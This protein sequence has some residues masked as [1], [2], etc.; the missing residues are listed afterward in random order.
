MR[1]IHFLLLGALILSGCGKLSNNIN[2]PLP[3]YDSQLVAECY[4]EPGVVPRLTVTESQTYLSSTLPVVP[5]DVMVSLS[6]PNGALVPLYYKPGQDPITKKYYTH[7]GNTPL[8]AQAGDTFGLD[9]QDTKGRHLT[10]TATMPTVVPIDSVAYKFNALTGADHKAYFLTYFQD[11]PTADDDYRLQLHQGR[12]I[13]GSA[14]VDLTIQ[15]RLINGQRVTLGT[16]YRFKPSDTITA[17][18]Y[19]IDPAYYRFRESVNDA[20]N[21]NGNP[22]GQPSAIYSTVAGGLGVFTVLSYTR[23]TMVL[24]AK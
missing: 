18:L 2:V 5:T 11:P 19:H 3:A 22:F 13:Y 12:R 15:D 7:I 17:T 6:L 10:G 9:V 8:V 1:S 4:L 14:E 23:K 20:R 21:A 24:T 16:R